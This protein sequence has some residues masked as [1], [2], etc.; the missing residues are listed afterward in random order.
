MGFRWSPVRIR[1]SRPTF[2]TGGYQD[3][4]QGL[5]GAG[6][7]FAI[8]AARFHQQLV[9]RLVD[10]ARNWLVRHGV[11]PED[12]DVIR[13]PGAWEIPLALQ[14]LADAGDHDALVALGAVIRGETAHF[15]YI[16]QGCSDGVLRVSLDHRL[17]I[18]FGV[19]TCETL[20]QAQAR[21]GGDAGN[22][23]EEAAAAALEMVAL[24]AG[25]TSASPRG[26]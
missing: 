22:K 20:E 19:L 14:L 3:S 12:I 21:A 11:R 4:D 23:G 8:V 18:G 16:C 2:V 25:V 7:R 26:H 9:D 6:Q 24:A 15:D 10:G 5:D 13:V 17:S 1:A